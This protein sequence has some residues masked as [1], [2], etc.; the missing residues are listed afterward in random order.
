MPR[1]VDSGFDAAVLDKEDQ[2][3]ALVQVKARPVERWDAILPSQLATLPE[4][5][6]FVFAIDPVHIQLF[7]PTEST[8]GYPIIQ[9][10]TQ[11]ILQHYDPELPKKRVFEFYLLTLVEAW[12]RDLAYHWKSATPPGTEELAKVGLLE[13]LA[14]G[15]TL[16]LGA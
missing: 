4:S 11:H 8:L 10:N 13:K 12:L 7:A 15:T 1:T 3:V 6:G 16:R 2:A 9:L 5:V 14:G